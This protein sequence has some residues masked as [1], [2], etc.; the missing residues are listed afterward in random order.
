MLIEPGYNT[1]NKQTNCLHNSW[2]K[3]CTQYE[4]ALKRECGRPRK[5]WQQCLNCDLKSLKLSKD[6]WREALRMADNPTCKKC[7]TWGK[8]NKVSMLVYIYIYMLI[9]MLYI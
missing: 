5:T 4:V 6:A 7:G 1:A 8:V 3:K 2:I 9:Y